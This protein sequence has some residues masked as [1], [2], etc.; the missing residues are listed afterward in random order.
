MLWLAL[1]VS[2]PLNGFSTVYGTAAVV[3]MILLAA[4][5]GLVFLL[6]K[7]TDQAERV[8]RAVF[9]QASRSSRRRPRPASSASSPA[10]SRR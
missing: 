7:G 6:M 3:G 9:R 4:A 8:L 10:A 5:G 2:I 1:L